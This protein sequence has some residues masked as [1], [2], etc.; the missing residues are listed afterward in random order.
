MA[1][2]NPVVFYRF[3]AAECVEIA[4]GVL[5]EGR[6]AKLLAIGQAWLTLAEQA[7]KNRSTTLV[8]ETPTPR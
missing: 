7:E 1:F 5:D 3:Y 6:R 2:N 4:Q 8:Y